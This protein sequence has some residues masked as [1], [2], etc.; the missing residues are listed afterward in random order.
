MRPAVF[1]I[2][3]SFILTTTLSATVVSEPNI[4]ASKIEFIDSNTPVKWAVLTRSKGG[5]L[6]ERVN[7]PGPIR[8][9]F[10]ASISIRDDEARFHSEDEVLDRINDSPVAKEFSKPQQ[11]FLTTG[12]AVRADT[13]SE[14]PY[15]YYGTCL[16]AVSEEDAKLMARAY[17]DGLSMSADQAIAR[18][19]TEL[20]KNQ[21][22]LC[23]AQK[24]LSEKEAKLRACEE[25]YRQEKDGLH[26][27]SSDVE[28][29]DLA[30]D[31]ILEMSKAL[32][33]LDI[34]MVGI[35]AKLN[36][37]EKYRDKKTQGDTLHAKLEEMFVEQTIE[38]SGLEARWAATKNL[39]DKQ[40]AFLDLYNERI[41]MQHEV[42]KLRVTIA[43]S[44]RAIDNITELL[45][46]PK[47]NT[48]FGNM[49]PTEVYENKVTIYP[50]LTKQS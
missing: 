40:K 3:L 8:P 28:A 31:T 7:P 26:K 9:T 20:I 44:Q 49:L 50:V 43:E 23:V 46:H 30:K 13:N 17:L 18:C 6:Y 35:R 48:I 27:L 33:R 5:N 39:S 11:E 1:S 25:K 2:V 47:Q 37:I 32:D 24:E 38:M 41:E 16:Y 21:E 45:A 19:K 12:F 22:K 14:D 36:A 15:H 42:S 4:T 10:A 29:Y 34:E